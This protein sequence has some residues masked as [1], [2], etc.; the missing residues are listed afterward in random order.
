[1]S[2]H[3]SQNAAPKQRQR[4]L[5]ELSK[6]HG[7]HHNRRKALSHSDCPPFKATNRRPKRRV[8]LDL[9][10]TS[11]QLYQEANGIVRTTNTLSFDR[12]STLQRFLESRTTVQMQLLANLRLDMNFGSRS[13]RFEWQKTINTCP[14][15]ALMNLHCLHLYVRFGGT[16]TDLIWL[17][18]VTR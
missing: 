17:H 13:H 14:V 7:L 5:Y 10:R 3:G 4:Q 1:M 11:R 6:Y 16:G 2:L 18:D 15:S 9:L 8:F 12:A